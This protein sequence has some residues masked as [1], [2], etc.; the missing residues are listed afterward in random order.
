MRPK[1]EE[2]EQIFFSVPGLD[3]S[4]QATDEATSPYTCYNPRSSRS[5]LAL[6]VWVPIVLTHWKTALDLQRRTRG[7]FPATQTQ[8]S[9]FIFGCD[10]YIIATMQLPWQDVR[11]QN[12][13][14]GQVEQLN[15][16]LPNNRPLHLMGNAEQRCAWGF[17]IYPSLS[18][19]VISPRLL[20][21][22]P[23]SSTERKKFKNKKKT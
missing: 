19:Q 15:L 10:S 21:M 12:Q 23:S 4:K 3:Q 1:W 9:E 2:I 6:S 22:L 18:L 20:F 17:H 14:L 5:L 7:F 16:P 13:C 11:A 8:H